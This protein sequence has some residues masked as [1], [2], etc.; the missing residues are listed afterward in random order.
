MKKKWP[1]SVRN[2]T[3]V[4]CLMFST[5]TEDPADS[6]GE[7]HVEDTGMHVQQLTQLTELMPLVTSSDSGLSSTFVPSIVTN[8]HIYIDAIPISHW[9]LQWPRQREAPQTSSANDTAVY[10]EDADVQPS[11]PARQSD[12]ARSVSFPPRSGSEDR[13]HQSPPAKRLRVHSDTDKVPLTQIVSVFPSF[14]VIDV[15]IYCRSSV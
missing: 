7:V 4:S 8:S 6:G 10:M 9:H 5:P 13:E 11:T 15:L 12:N 2:V 14:A 1:S 3:V